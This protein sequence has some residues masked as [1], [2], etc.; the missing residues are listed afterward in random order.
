MVT[1]SNAQLSTNN[2]CYA[3]CLAA[4]Q[5]MGDVDYIS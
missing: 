5:F 1:F 3:C 2:T 4:G